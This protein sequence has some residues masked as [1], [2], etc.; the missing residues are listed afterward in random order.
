MGLLDALHT[1]SQ[2]LGLGYI[3]EGGTLDTPGMLFR[4]CCTWAH[5]VDTVARLLKLTREQMLRA[6]GLDTL[7][8]RRSPHGIIIPDL[9]ELTRSRTGRRRG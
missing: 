7:D 8:W 3:N 2:T 5:G 6:E 4:N 1:G 9:N